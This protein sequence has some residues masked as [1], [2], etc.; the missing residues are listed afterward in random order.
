MANSVKSHF[1]GNICAGATTYLN[2]LKTCQQN[3]FQGILVET[4]FELT[5]PF[6][7]WWWT[8]LQVRWGDVRSLKQERSWRCLA[9]NFKSICRNLRKPQIKHTALYIRLFLLVDIRSKTQGK[10]NLKL[11]LK[12]HQ[13]SRIFCSNLK[14]PANFSE[15]LKDFLPNIMNL[16]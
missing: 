2:C 9:K 5:G 13:N 10:R 14:I 4:Y 16:V 1:A 15:I 11:K 7:W 6:L 3:F 8:G 12:K